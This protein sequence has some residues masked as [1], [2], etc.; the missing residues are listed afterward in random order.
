MLKNSNFLITLF[1]IT[2]CVSVVHAHP[3]VWADAQV[4]AQFDKSKKI[5]EISEI[6]EF[7]EMFSELIIE[8]YDK[9][10][11][12]IFSKKESVAIKNGAF[13]H[14][15]ED[16]FYTYIFVDGER[17][18][19][20]KLKNFS[21][22]LEKGLVVYM[23]T[24]SLDKPIDPFKNKTSIGVYDPEFYTEILYKRNKVFKVKG[25][26]SSECSYKISE[27]KEHPIYF[28]MVNPKKIDVC[29]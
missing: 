29:K 28:D 19:N 7:D 27:D 26:S 12:K 11:D 6:W 16:G 2:F 9:N 14:L 24:L 3:H 25:I 23:F 4:V 20:Y 21:A 13:K 22:K 17:Y 18:K 10:K 1:F 5:I 15:S 8:D